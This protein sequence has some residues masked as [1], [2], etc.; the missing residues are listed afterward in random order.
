MVILIGL[1][2]QLATQF[3]T[4]ISGRMNIDI[5]L[6]VHQSLQLIIR[7]DKGVCQALKSTTT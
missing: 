2:K 4:A 3:S 6:P 5:K 1:R 7:Q